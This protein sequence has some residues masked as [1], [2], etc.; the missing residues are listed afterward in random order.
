MET[1]FEPMARITDAN[2]SRNTHDEALI[3][4]KYR[5]KTHTHKDICNFHDAKRTDGFSDINTRQ[6]INENI[7]KRKGNER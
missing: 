1:S 3:K 7:N 5:E 4:E 6:R 2:R